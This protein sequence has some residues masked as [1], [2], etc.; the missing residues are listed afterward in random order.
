MACKRQITMKA[1][2]KI[3]DLVKRALTFVQRPLSCGLPVKSP[4]CTPRGRNGANQMC[5]DSK[6]ERANALASWETAAPNVQPL[7]QAWNVGRGIKG[8]QPELRD[9]RWHVRQKAPTPSQHLWT[10]YSYLIQKSRSSGCPSHPCAVQAVPPIP[11][12][13][14]PIPLPSRSLPSRLDAHHFSNAL[15]NHRRPRSTGQ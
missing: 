6:G 8:G 4:K 2:A 13:I 3:V 14:P 11:P 1:A 15:H 5:V 7:I 10:L 9:M 12:P